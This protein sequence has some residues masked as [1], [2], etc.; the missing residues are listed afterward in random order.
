MPVTG[1]TAVTTVT[2]VTVV[3][4]RECVISPR[5]GGLVCARRTPVTAVTAVAPVTPVTAVT[6][7]I[8]VTGVTA[9]IALTPSRLRYV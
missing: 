7:V 1:A 6:A 4:R 5:H 3:I 2:G 8:T 9:V